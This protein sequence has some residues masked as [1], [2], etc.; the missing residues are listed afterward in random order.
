[1]EYEVRRLYPLP[2]LSGGLGILHR[3]ERSIAPPC[4]LGTMHRGPGYRPATIGAAPRPPPDEWT[5]FD[6]SLASIQSSW[7]SGSPR[8]PLFAS[9]P[10]SEFKLCFPLYITAQMSRKVHGTV[11]ML[12]QVSRQFKR[13]AP[14]DRLPSTSSG[15]TNA[16][17]MPALQ[18][19]CTLIQDRLDSMGKKAI[20]HPKWRQFTRRGAV[21]HEF[22]NLW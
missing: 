14:F 1:M 11:W 9:E 3:L 20:C 7:S 6:P 12:S 18:L 13:P 22:D 19:G 5:G 16:G 10:N 2:R 21:I 15:L 17:K 8:L 4:P